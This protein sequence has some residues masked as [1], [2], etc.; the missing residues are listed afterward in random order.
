MSIDSSPVKLYYNV[1]TPE[2]KKPDATLL[3]IHGM[4]EYSDRYADFAKYFAEF[5]FVVLTYDHPGHGKSINKKGDLGFFQENN[6]DKQLI[7]D[8][9]AMNEYLVTSYPE[10]PHFILGHSM[11]SFVAR[12]LLNKNDKKFN[13]AIIVG[14]GGE[15]AGIN[16]L[17][18]YFSWMNK[19]SPR[20]LTKFNSVF[21]YMNNSKFRKENLNS[22]VNWLS[23]NVKNRD[24]Y[25]KDELCGLPFSN[26]G[27]YTLFSIYKKATNRKWASN[28]K[29]TFPMLFVSGQ[30]DTIGNFSKGVKQ[31]IDNLKTDGFT[32]ITLKLYNEMRHEILNEDIREEVFHDI[33]N[34]ILRYLKK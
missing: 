31:V 23:L 19:V 24:A 12:C 29:K 34:W 9:E 25:D 14:T 26:N 6:P 21:N 32:D 4:Q 20:K 17:I 27:F 13:G 3:V 8:A 1:F 2:N 16:L 18:S 22:N 28:I 11:G 30:N 7:E 5:G 15:L 10:I 33:Y